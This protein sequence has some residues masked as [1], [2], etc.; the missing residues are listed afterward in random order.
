MKDIRA[1]IFD[2][3]NT[4]LAF[5]RSAVARVEERLIALAPGLPRGAT[6]AHW[7]G[8]PGPWPRAAA[9]EP[10]FWR[11]FWGSLAARH[12]LPPEDAAALDTLGDFYHTCFTPFPDAKPCVRALHAHG[13]RLAVL[14]NFELPSIDRTLRHAGID[15]GLFDALLSSAATGFPKPDPRAYHAAADALGLPL[16]A[17]LLV[18]DLPA[19]VEGARRAGMPA[20][21]LDR[22]GQA[23][24]GPEMVTSLAALLVL[25]NRQYKRC[26]IS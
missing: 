6:A 16:S 22:T 18:D 9:D 3:D 5:D 24:S 2:R 8:W 15:P 4:L 10:A 23:P 25:I 19:N 13:L 17:C 11:T 14:S 7:L 26:I 21:L 12:G 1:V 20:L